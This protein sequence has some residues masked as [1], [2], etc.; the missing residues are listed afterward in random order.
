MARLNWNKIGKQARIAEGGFE[1]GAEFG[2]VIDRT[3]K[4][5]VIENLKL[6]SAHP[7]PEKGSRGKKKQQIARREVALE[8]RAAAS[9]AYGKEILG[10]LDKSGPL[11]AYNKA[12]D[13]FL[14]NSQPVSFSGMSPSARR[15]VET[16]IIV[17][18]RVD[19]AHLASKP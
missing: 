5:A 18:L 2:D 15:L 10:I 4:A 3:R 14:R 12:V 6:A 17:R 16:L 9:A 13:D 19:G 11:A 8:E 7:V 1:Q